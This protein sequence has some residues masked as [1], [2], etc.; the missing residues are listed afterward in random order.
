MRQLNFG[1]QFG[2]LKAES[3]SLAIS[4]DLAVDSPEM[5]YLR[6]EPWMNT[7]PPSLPMAP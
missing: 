5:F 7:R 1:G 2:L 4:G 6:L 3:C